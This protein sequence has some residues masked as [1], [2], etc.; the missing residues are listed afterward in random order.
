MVQSFALKSRRYILNRRQPRQ[1][2]KSCPNFIWQQ[3]T[4]HQIWTPV[5]INSLS[6]VL[7]HYEESD[8]Y[9]Q[10]NIFSFCSN[11]KSP[12][13]EDG[14]PIITLSFKGCL[15][16]QPML[17]LWERLHEPQNFIFH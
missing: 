16:Y 15:D 7:G 12:T 2:L 1:R 6:A 14:Y 8:I 5:K 4:T 13:N 3:L 17:P 9:I 10:R 11:L